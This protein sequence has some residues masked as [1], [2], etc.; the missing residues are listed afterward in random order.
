MNDKEH[1]MS[2]GDFFKALLGSETVDEL[3]KKLD[4]LEE[5]PV[6]ERHLCQQTVDIKT[7]RIRKAVREFEGYTALAD[8]C[9]CPNGRL[10]MLKRAEGAMNIALANGFKPGIPVR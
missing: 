5:A 3:L 8:G 7:I 2:F 10:A 9:G 6:Y 4:Q 1:Y